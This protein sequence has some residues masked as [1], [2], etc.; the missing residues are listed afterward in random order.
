[1]SR[2]LVTMMFAASVAVLS[3]APGVA[4]ATVDFLTVDFL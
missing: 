2:R 3:A 1:M 4:M